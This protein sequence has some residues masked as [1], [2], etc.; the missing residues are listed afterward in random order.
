MRR[1]AY[2][3]LFMSRETWLHWVVL[4]E[5]SQTAK[6]L[7]ILCAGGGGQQRSSPPSPPAGR[8]PQLTR[9]NRSTLRSTPKS[10]LQTTPSPHDSDRHS[11]PLIAPSSAAYAL[12]INRGDG[13]AVGNERGPIRTGRQGRRGGAERGWGRGCA[14][15]A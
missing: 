11:E 12:P 9:N 7:L 3:S 10:K 8:T 14:Y 5:N 15:L 4:L 13:G 2:L 1:E 6:S